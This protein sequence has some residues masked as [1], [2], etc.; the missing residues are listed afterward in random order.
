[1][2]AGGGSSPGGSGPGGTGPLGRS[3]GGIGLAA[4]LAG[5]LFAAGFLIQ[6]RPAGAAEPQAGAPARAE[7]AVPD[8]ADQLF[9]TPQLAGVPPGMVLTYAYARTVTDPE[10]GPSF[11]DRIRL[12]IEPKQVTSEARDVTVDFFS[13]ERHRAAGPF[14]NTR[15]NPVLMLF[16]ENHIADL[17]RTLKSNPRYFKNAIRAALR[18]AAEVVPADIAVDG[19]QLTG[20]RITIAPFRDDANATRMRGLGSLVYTFETVPGLP[21]HIARISVAAEAPGGRLWEESIRY[22]P[23]GS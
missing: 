11:T 13:A 10:L 2:N 21:G 8:A 23:K 14:E 22:D 15:T 9:D 20:W 16:L 3:L 7:R 5:A 12:A 4:V 1:M 6:P 19:R 18:D 17:A